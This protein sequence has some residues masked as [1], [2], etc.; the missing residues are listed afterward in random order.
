VHERRVEVGGL[1]EERR[2]LGA[3]MRIGKAL[4]EVDARLEELEQ[5][6]NIRNLAGEEGQELDSTESEEDSEDESVANAV[7]VSRLQRRVQQ[8]VSAKRLMSKVGL[9]HPFIV[10][11]GDRID[12]IRE[13]LLLDLSGALKQVKKSGTESG[14]TRLLK[15]LNIYRDMGEHSEAI[16][17]LKN[18]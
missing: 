7:P 18:K 14:N 1:I 6:L 10:K 2:E 8:Y 17:V 15:I 5:G 3:Q 13:T 11:Q 16:T 12:A 9:E 4:L